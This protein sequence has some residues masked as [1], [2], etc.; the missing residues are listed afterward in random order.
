MQVYVH[1]DIDTLASSPGSLRGRC[2]TGTIKKKKSSRNTIQQDNEKKKETKLKLQNT[3]SLWRRA[4]ETVKP[5][6]SIPSSEADRASFKC[7]TESEMGT[8]TRKP[9]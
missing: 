6:S 3:V 7:R 8:P 4:G 2:R 5:M 9:S 1:N